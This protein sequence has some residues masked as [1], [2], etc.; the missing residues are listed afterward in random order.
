MTTDTKIYDEPEP[1][2]RRR[3]IPAGMARV[4]VFTRTYETTAED[5]WDA[6]TNP[7]RLRLG[8]DTCSGPTVDV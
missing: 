7:E 6:C 4:A 3:M 5:L 8:V 1:E 2:L